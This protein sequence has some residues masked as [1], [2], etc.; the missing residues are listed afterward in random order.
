M[1]WCIFSCIYLSMYRLIDLCDQM[2]FC[3]LHS[4]SITLRN[5][6][7][8][9][10]RADKF[11]NARNH[12]CSDKLRRSG[13]RLRTTVLLDFLQLNTLAPGMAKRWACLTRWGSSDALVWCVMQVLDQRASKFQIWCVRSQQSS[14]RC[15]I[16]DWF[17]CCCF[18]W[19]AK[20][21][22]YT[23]ATRV[24]SQTSAYDVAFDVPSWSKRFEAVDTHWKHR[25][26]R[27]QIAQKLP[28]ERLPPNWE[29]LLKSV[30]WCQAAWVERKSGIHQWMKMVPSCKSLD[31]IGLWVDSF[32]GKRLSTMCH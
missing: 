9:K 14:T 15:L 28:S 24:G 12:Q 23:N 31:F 30:S 13:D 10:T 3:N 22:K 19:P 27:N 17:Y 5:I 8:P 21:C 29:A 6:F 2:L 16:D 32:A 26:I 25:K 18:N 1:D 4:I 7:A 20:S 11:T